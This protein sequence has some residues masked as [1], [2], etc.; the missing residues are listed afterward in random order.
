M[1]AKLPQKE[2]EI[3]WRCI[4]EQENKLKEFAK[5]KMVEEWKKEM[6]EIREDWFK[7][8]NINL[9]KPQP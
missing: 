8:F 1:I 2:A 5:K 9:N 7:A 6:Q 4:V 3:L